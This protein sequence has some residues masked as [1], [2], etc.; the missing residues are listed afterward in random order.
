[1]VFLAIILVIFVILGFLY[2]KFYLKKVISYEYLN[3]FVMSI[4]VLITAFYASDTRKMAF[5]MKKTNQ[6]NLRPF[7]LIR[8]ENI[9]YDKE[10]NLIFPVNL[11]NVG[12][13][14][15]KNVRLH[16]RLFRNDD[17]IKNWFEPEKE[18]IVVFPQEEPPLRHLE[19][20]GGYTIKQDKLATDLF[21]IQFIVTYNGFKDI[22]D[23]TY[24]TL[25][26]FKLK[27]LSYEQ[28]GEVWTNEF[29][30]AQPSSDEGFIEER[31]IKNKLNVCK[32]FNEQ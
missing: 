28:K 31:E 3:V 20:I 1:M 14:P 5:E 7:L 29:S 12:S 23:R 25:A 21:K 6:I 26:N 15:A 27:P 24:Y 2:I 32:D 9:F 17:C 4:L 18:K 13:A 11:V 16:H 30:V 22:D 19:E 10:G 8:G